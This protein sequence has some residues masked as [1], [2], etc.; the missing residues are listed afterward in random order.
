M[1]SIKLEGFEEAA[2]LFD[3]KNVRLAAR[4]T[5]TRAASSGKK[6]ASEEIRK[7]YNVR[8]SDLNP[9]IKSYAARMSDLTA[10][11]V[12]TGRPMSLS[13][14]GAQQITRSNVITRGNEGLVSKSNKRLRSRGPLQ[15][16]VRVEVRKGN[17][18]VLRQAFMARMKSGHIGV[19]YRRT[20]G[21]SIYERNVITIPSMVQNAKVMPNVIERIQQSMAVE[22]PRQLK[23]Y[24]S[25]DNR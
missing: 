11:V 1:I 21:R 13:Y 3:P 9:R 5:L 10:E 24:M 4:Q 22:F 12:I 20:T 18:V 17:P 14:F 2:K 25:R 7:I 15:V 23:Y 6:V 8:P 19:F 16:G